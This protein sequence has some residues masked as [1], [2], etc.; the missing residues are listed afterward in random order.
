MLSIHHLNFHP[1]ERPADDTFQG[2][3]SIRRPLLGIVNKLNKMKKPHSRSNSS[4]AQL[5]PMNPPD[6]P[7]MIKRPTLNRGANDSIQPPD[8]PQITK[9][10]TPN[11]AAHDPMQ[12]PDRPH[13]TKRHTLNRAVDKVTT[14]LRRVKTS[15]NLKVLH[16]S[17]ESR[18]QLF[19]PAL[20]QRKHAQISISQP[21]LS[22][23]PVTTT[24]SEAL[25]D[26]L[27]A[28]KN[29]RSQLWANNQRKLEGACN[30]YCG[31]CDW[32][33]LPVFED[34]ELD[35]DSSVLDP[36]YKKQIKTLQPR[37]RFVT[38][39]IAPILRGSEPSD[40]QKEPADS[41]IKSSCTTASTITA[42]TKDSEY[43]CTA[44]TAENIT[45]PVRSRRVS[46]A[47]Q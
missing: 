29:F 4:K 6:K 8:R 39:A 28:P 17:R 21:C 34:D 2:P 9:R 23:S 38:D 25:L 44:V 45:I 20:I 19:A 18:D 31:T 12:P 43:R 7:R 36:D 16:H 32:Q 41:V 37:S 30:Y 14:T 15:A 3:R 33:S 40:P 1:G 26:E 24:E 46:Q 22:N 42:S 47:A 11:R 27:L 35:P 10:H 13:I 5:D